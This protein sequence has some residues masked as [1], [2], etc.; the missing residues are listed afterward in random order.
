[1]MY[2]DITIEI[3]I[4]KLL[5]AEDSEINPVADRFPVLAGCRNNF[6]WDTN[7]GQHCDHSR[8]R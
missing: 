6:H 8:G 5:N 7:N 1:M 2:L 3:G 4:E